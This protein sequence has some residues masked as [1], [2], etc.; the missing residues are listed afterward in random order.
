MTPFEVYCCYLSLKN[1]FTR[2]TYDYFKYQGKTRASVQSFNKRKDKYF[3]EKTSRQKS[4]QEILN[5]FVSNFVNCDD[6]QKL[7]IGGIIQS[8][9]QNYSD[10]KRRTQSLS[11]VFRNETEDLF[12]ESDIKQVFS[13]KNGHP[14]ILKKFL[15]GSISIET[16]VIYDKVFSFS[17]NFDKRLLDPVWE[18]VSMRIKKYSPFLNIETGQYKKIIREFLLTGDT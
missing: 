5:Y 17:E 6:P 14:T 8:G 11:Y 9:E 13:C 2:N 15:R 12:Y 4:D 3:F 18:S 7:W 16:L 1:H 10:W